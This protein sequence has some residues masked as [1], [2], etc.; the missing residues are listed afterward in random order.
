KENKSQL[1]VLSAPDRDHRFFAQRVGDKLEKE[2]VAFL[3]VEAAPAPAALASQLGL[4]RGTGLVIG[5]VAAKSPA[6]GVLQQH[7]VLLKLDDQILIE[8]HQLSVL[9]R[10]HKEGDEVTLTYMRAG[11]QTTAK[12]KLGIH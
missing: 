6:D 8:P 10:Q 4:A 12:V 11:K 9:I 3:G 5:H 2:N 1:R 7:D